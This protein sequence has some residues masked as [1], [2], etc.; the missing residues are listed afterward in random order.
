M[1]EATRFERR[2]AKRLAIRTD[3]IGRSVAID[4]SASNGRWIQNHNAKV[5]EIRGVER[6]QPSDSITLHR[7]HEADV[8]G[9][10]PHHEVPLNQ[11]LPKRG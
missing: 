10:N 1:G 4:G 9:S 6:K 8:M 11:L 5:A 7:R 3:P 2:R